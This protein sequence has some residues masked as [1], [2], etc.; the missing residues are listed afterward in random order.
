MSF[1]FFKKDPTLFHIMVKYSR[2]SLLSWPLWDTRCDG[3]RLWLWVA[4]HTDECMLSFF[5]F[6]NTN[7]EV[8]NPQTV[9][10]EVTYVMRWC[11]F[12]LVFV[13]YVTGQLR[14][15]IFHCKSLSLPSFLF[16]I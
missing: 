13:F 4:C 12:L 9:W 1:S 11:Y 7:V 15:Y 16:V 2:L 8:I 14:W 10:T 6:L 3:E 5:F